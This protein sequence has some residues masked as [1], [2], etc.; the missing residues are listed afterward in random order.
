M[1]YPT[2]MPG[3][4]GPA[5]QGYS[6]MQPYPPT[7]PGNQGQMPQPVQPQ[8]ALQGLS[9]TSRPVSS[10]E[11]AMGI[12]A[13][14]S[15][16]LMVF[17]DVSHNRVYLKRWNVAAG[18]ADFLEYAPVA[19]ME[20]EPAPELPAFAPLQDLQDL[21]SVVEELKKEVEKAKL[22]AATVRPIK[23]EKG[24]SGSE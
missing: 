11:E 3:S 24:D 16:S 23:K 12:A 7:L 5:I 10:R 15:G 8:P 20:P 19:P 17:P 14:F 6:P 18:S 13:D 9:G 21:Q 22:P 4:Y 2:Y 1:N